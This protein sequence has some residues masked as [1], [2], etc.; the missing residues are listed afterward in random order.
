MITAPGVLI[1]SGKEASVYRCPAHGASGCA[2]AAIKI[3]K[4]IESRS[5][6]GAKE[7]LDGRI[8]RTIRKRRD[9]LHML[10]SSA[11]MQAYWVDS[12]RS[13][14]ESLYSAGL[15]VPKPLAAT[16]SAFAMEFISEGSEAAPRLIE[17][18]LEG[19]RGEVVLAELL[20]A[21][22]AMLALDIIHGDLSPYNILVRG[23]RPVIIDLPQAAD[24]RYSSNAFALLARDIRNALGY[25]QKRGIGLG[26][27]PERE[28]DTLW[29]D[30][31]SGALYRERDAA[32][33]AKEWGLADLAY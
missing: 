9:I 26:H 7:Y 11:S 19:A 29:A 14:M 1:K 6:K 8:G 10:S 28:A 25:F 30:Y 16:A 20:G 24:A 27:D 31:R 3:Y 22:R 23:G 12:E 4:D 2:E 18:D 33:L 5:F 21:L 13:A 17:L 32:Q 15:P